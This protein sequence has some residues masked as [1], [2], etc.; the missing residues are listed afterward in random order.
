LGI[1]VLPAAGAA[2]LLMAPAIDI[3]FQF[4]QPRP[5]NPDSQI[6]FIVAVPIGLFALVAELVRTFQ[7]GSMFQT[8]SSR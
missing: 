2:V 1:A 8:S 5:G 4:A 3:F 6:L 7:P